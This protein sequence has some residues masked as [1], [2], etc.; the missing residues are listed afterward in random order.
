MRSRLQLP[1]IFFTRFLILIAV[2]ATSTTLIFWTSVLAQHASEQKN[3]IDYSSNQGVLEDEVLKK[4]PN[5]LADN[6]PTFTDEYP[7]RLPSFTAEDNPEATFWTDY[8]YR[9]HGNHPIHIQL[10]KNNYRYQ[11]AAE[12]RSDGTNPD[13][14]N[15]IIINPCKGHAP[16]CCH[17]V[18]GFPEYIRDLGNPLLQHVVDESNDV[19]DQAHSRLQDVESIIDESCV[20]N[21]T[22]G[23]FPK[24]SCS[25]DRISV[26]QS[27]D[28]PFCWDH[29]TTVDGG[30]S[31]QD[32]EG[33]VAPRCMQVGYTQNAYIVECGGDLENDPHCGTY[34][35]IH[36]T[37]DETIINEVHLPGG[38]P[39][40]YRTTTIPLSFKGYPNRVSKWKLSVVSA[41]IV[42]HILLIAVVVVVVVVVVAAV[43]VVVTF[44]LWESEAGW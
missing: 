35:E 7:H 11:A 41:S 15:N 27:A 19:I 3:A 28:R 23:V 29:N 22:T 33:N 12:V 36:K 9:E 24:V 17:D 21:E 16:D 37:G 6:Y 38:F 1:T 32:S 4:H 10:N 25:A 31:C 2:A 30:A 8:P 13:Y 40:G 44:Y 14:L 20:V 43:V 34:L 42:L 26:Q 5:L 18:F 39:S